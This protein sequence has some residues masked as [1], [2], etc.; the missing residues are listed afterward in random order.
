MNKSTLA[1]AVAALLVGG[2]AVAAFQHMRAPESV[3]APSALAAPSSFDMAAD[4]P[5][6]DTSM[7]PVI[8]S[9]RRRDDAHPQGRP[10]DSRIVSPDGLAPVWDKAV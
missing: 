5:A 7:L 10:P 1:I 4:V 8:S 2:V 9:P 6:T 3:A